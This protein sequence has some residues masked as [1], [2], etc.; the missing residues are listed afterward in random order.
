MGWRKATGRALIRVAGAEA[1]AFLQGL[2]TNDAAQATEERAVYGALL[3]PQG[4]YLADFFIFAH[5][6]AL[7]LDVAADQRAGAIQRL[8]LYRLRRQIEIAADDTPV[9]RAWGDSPAPPPGALKDPRDPRLGWLIY[10][11]WSP[12]GA[13]DPEGYE[14]LRLTVGAPDSGRDLIPNDTYILEAGFE[15]LN[16]VDFKKGCY[17]GQEI[18]ARMKH[19]TELRKGMMQVSLDDDAAQ[20]AQ[21]GAALTSADGK[22][23]GVLTSRLG[24]VGLAHLRFDRAAAPMAVEGGGMATARR[25]LE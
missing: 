5:G 11:D 25:L 19:K 24:G 2:V 12:E 4:K 22:P 21:E 13:A 15:R 10:G 14:A 20:T 3:T 1:T 23:A 6:G 18:V 8:T 9:W 7:M 17:V 16:G